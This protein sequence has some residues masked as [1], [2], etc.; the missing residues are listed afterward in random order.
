MF[1]ASREVSRNKEG[2]RLG[3]S[4]FQIGRRIRLVIEIRYI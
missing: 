3:V 4:S 1:A 2:C